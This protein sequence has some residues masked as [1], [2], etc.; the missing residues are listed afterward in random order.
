VSA[1]RLAAPVRSFDCCVVLVVI[2]KYCLTGNSSVRLLP[3]CAAEKAAAQPDSLVGRTVGGGVFCRLLGWTTTIVV[4]GGSVVFVGRKDSTQHRAASTVAASRR[5]SLFG[6]A[7]V[8]R[9]EPFAVNVQVPDALA[10]PLDRSAVPC[11]V[12]EAVVVVVAAKHQSDRRRREKATAGQIGGGANRRPL[13][14]VKEKGA[15][16]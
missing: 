13:N 9:R 6:V 7:R 11:R 14:D 3:T 5:R 2:L 1:E 8:L 16:E 10:R 4:G 15:A 12:E